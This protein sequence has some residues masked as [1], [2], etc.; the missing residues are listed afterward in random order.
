MHPC[1]GR[2][3]LIPASTRTVQMTLHGDSGGD[4]DKRGGSNWSA[5][6]L[7]TYMGIHLRKRVAGIIAEEWSYGESV[8]LRVHRAVGLARLRGLIARERMTSREAMFF[9]NCRSVHGAFMRREITVV[10]LDADLGIT[11][12]QRLKPW[13]VAADRGAKHALEMELPV[14]SA[15]DPN[16][17]EKNFF[18][19]RGAN[20]ARSNP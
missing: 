18:A 6:T 9:E 2:L 8:H 20:F 5:Q 17:S 16:W 10:F 3:R 14:E 7:N 4:R 12:V 15:L 19:Q 11:S 1:V 13:R